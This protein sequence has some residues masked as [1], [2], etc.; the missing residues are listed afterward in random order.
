MRVTSNLLKQ[1]G[2]ISITADEIVR[3]IKE[4]IGE[5]DYHHNLEDDYKDIVIA[6]IKEKED[7]PDADKLG[8]YQI[9][10]GAKETI[11]VV[12]GDRLLQVGD[13]IAYLKV[14]SI[15]PYSIYTEAE[16]FIL[17]AVK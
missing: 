6:E 16:P 10:F 11:Q 1:F 17:K 5:V 13:K 4:H 8:I 15:V 3:L 7:H 9:D 12:A 2:N 14:G